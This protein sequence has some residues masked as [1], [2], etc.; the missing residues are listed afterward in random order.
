M[1]GHDKTHPPSEFNKEVNTE[2]R[3]KGRV[4]RGW[5]TFS[6]FAMKL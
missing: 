5:N 2:V 4:G 3:D 6:F 1:S